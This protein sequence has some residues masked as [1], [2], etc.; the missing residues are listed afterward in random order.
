MLHFLVVLLGL[1]CLQGGDPICPLMG[2]LRAGLRDANSVRVLM[3]GSHV[4][5]SEHAG[6]DFE[7][8]ACYTWFGLLQV[9]DL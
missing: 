9:K 6:A 7:T 4:S 2:H 8:C 1:P 3:H 5:L